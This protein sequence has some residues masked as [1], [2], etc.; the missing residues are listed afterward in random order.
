[1]NKII[2]FLVI[3]IILRIFLAATT[4]HPDLQTFNL[5]GQIIASGHILDIYDYLQNLPNDHSWKNLA[6]FNYPPAIYLFHGIFNFIFS[7]IFQLWQVNYFMMDVITNY[8]NFQF[9][10]HLALLKLPYLIFDLLTAFFL[11]KLFESRKDRLL[12][13]ALWIFNPINLYATYMM[14]Q[15]D[16]IPTTFS[17]LAMVVATKGKLS[18][19]ALL[20]GFGIAFKVFPI[21]LLPILVLLANRW[22]ERIKIGLIALTPYLLS[23]LPFL[24][25]QGFRTN[26]F[27]ADQGSKSLYAVL[28][29]SGGE[30]IFLFPFFLLTFYLILLRR[31][32]SKAY[33]NRYF[34]ITFLLFFIF[35]HFHPQWLLW[36]TPFIIICLVKEKTRNFVQILVLFIS[37]AISLFFFES[38][39][40]INLFAP[41]IPSLKALPP[42]WEIINRP[43][44][45][46]YARSLTQTIFAAA[47]FYL[48]Y[49]HFPPQDAQ[50]K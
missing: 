5:S 17:V 38:S 18:T 31:G 28:P 33:L 4:Y 11:M 25:S 3:G 26:A 45:I 2:I 21:F 46:N 40:T 35:T 41:L 22:S 7:N 23:L 32:V 6:L 16:I 9:N 20:L 8:G 14:G 50:D 36:V 29:I 12:I 24:S 19:A 10:I 27:F 15:F 42:I 48:I 34:L 37:Y 43:I 47:A 44:D 30:M 49:I 39:L 1:M 13:F